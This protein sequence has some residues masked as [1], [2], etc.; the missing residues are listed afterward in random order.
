MAGL[1]ITLLGSFA[2]SANGREIGP[3]RTK[4]AQALLVFLATEHALGANSHQRE[5]LMEMLWPDLPQKSAQV[6]LRQVLYQLRQG[7]PSLPATAADQ[8]VPFFS[9][10]RRAVTLIIRFS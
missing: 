8:H 4:R 10:D 1:L 9:A 7:V 2:I 6:N 5:A 3:L